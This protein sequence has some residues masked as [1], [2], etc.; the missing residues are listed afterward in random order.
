MSFIEAASI[1]VIFLT[2]HYSLNYIGKLKKGERILI[3]AAAG[4]VG[5]AAIQIAQHLGAEVFATVGT[6]EKHEIIASLG[7][8]HI[9]NSRNTEFYD[10]I[11]QITNGEGVDVVL[12]S[13]TSKDFIPKSLSCLKP[14]G[15]FLEIAKHDIWTPEQVKEYRPDVQYSIIAIDV[16]A[17]EQ[18]NLIKQMMTEIMSDFAAGYYKPIKITSYPITEAKSA[19][20]FMAQGKH[21]GKIVFDFIPN[22]N[23]QIKT[24][25][26]KDN[27]CYLVTG[28]LGALGFE[29]AKWLI[30]KGAKNLV[31]LGRKSPSPEQQESIAQWHQEAINVQAPQCDIAKIADVK[32]MFSNL[33]VN[34]IAEYS[35]FHVAG[36][37][38]D[39]TIMQQDYEKYIYVVKSKIL[40]ALNVYNHINSNRFNLNSFISFS[41]TTAVIGNVGQSNYAAAN[42][43]LDTF[44][45]YVR[46]IGVNAIS[47]NWGAWAQ[48]GLAANINQAS[49]EQLTLNGIQAFNPDKGIQAL[50][51]LL[52]NQNLKSEVIVLDINWSKFFTTIKL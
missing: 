43:F 48:I 2:V 31:L 50:E 28:G 20:R 18:P 41:S 23:S 10:E 40:G 3:H 17:K 39:A 29:V 1:P 30:N 34:N 9:M 47:I 8:K 27:I 35:V 4:G 13:L 22:T 36:I 38:D 16:L 12:N 5:L 21:T 52:L 42:T 33:K 45:H 11:M 14:Q 7:V 44:M 51:K 19:F 25:T 6:Q 46:S 37:L 24:F 26:I 32:E 15:R 49:K